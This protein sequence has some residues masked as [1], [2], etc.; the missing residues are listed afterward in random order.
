MPV[1]RVRTKG[2]ELMAARKPGREV[3]RMGDGRILKMVAEEGRLT[4]ASAVYEAISAACESGALIA[5]PEELVVTER[6]YAMV[7]E[8]AEGSS[9]DTLVGQG[10]VTPEQAGEMLATCL[11]GLHLLRGDATRMRDVREPFLRMAQDLSPLLSPQTT[12][13]LRDT[14]L[15]LPPTET[16]VHCDVHMGNVIVGK[17]GGFTL[18]DA[19]TV[20]IGAPVVDLACSYSTMVCETIIDPV[21]AERFHGM[22]TDSVKSVWESLMRHYCAETGMEHS[23][24]TDCQMKTIAWLLVLNRLHRAAACDEP[25]GKSALRILRALNCLTKVVGLATL[26]S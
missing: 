12:E 6:G 22:R 1:R 21:R 26:C 5:R 20:S 25:F 16:L 7:Q 18:I 2:L 17:D 23:G 24:K 9:L 3:Y 4:R 19:D 10:R 8:F 15:G 13:A 14:I 11:L